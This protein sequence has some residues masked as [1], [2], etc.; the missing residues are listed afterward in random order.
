M[1]FKISFLFVLAAFTGLLFAEEAKEQS[2]EAVA[3]NQELEN[4]LKYV[5]ALVDSG[6]P[7][8]ATLVSEEVK[9][10]WPEAE[11]S[12]FAL[13]VR[14]LLA[15]GKFKEA[16]AKIA[17]L[18]D[19]TGTKY[20]AARL[21]M[22]NS[23]F[24]RGLK[25]ECM[26]IYEE[27][28]SK[29]AKPTKDIA[30]FYN[31]ANWV[32]GQ[33]LMRDNKFDKAVQRYEYALKL[34]KGEDW[35][36]LACETADI[37]LKLIEQSKEKSK[38]DAY[39]KAVTVIINKLLYQFERPVFFGR[40]L[41]MKAHIELLKGDSERAAATIEEYKA[42]LDNLHAQIVE[43][44]PEGKFGLL[45]QSPLPQCLYLKAKILWDEAKK[46]Y[47]SPTRKDERVKELLFGKK[48]GGRRKVETGAFAIAQ[49]IF[50]NYETSS[51]APAAGDMAQEIREFA[52]KNY[53]A[54]IKTRVTDEQREKVR[55]AQFREANEKYVA[56]L[57][58]EAVVAYY[59]VLSRY[60][61]HID[62][63][64][65]VERIATVL[66]D[67]Y[68]EA[69][70]EA[71]KEEKRLDC[72]TIEGYLAERFTGVSNKLIMIGAGDALVRLAAKEE[73]YRD[74]D[75]S[76]AL[77]AAFCGNYTLHPGSP[78]TAASKAG[79][80]QKKK[81]YDKAIYFWNFL[82]NIY[83]NSVFHATA[84]SQLSYCYGEKGDVTNE[85]AYISRYV[86]VEKNKLRKLQAQLKLA[87]MY[88]HSGLELLNSCTNALPENVEALERKGTAQN[89]RAIQNFIKLEKEAGEA[90][91]DPATP[92][93]DKEKFGKARET[94]AYL[95]G[96]CFSRMKRPEKNLQMYRQKAAENFE[97]YIK[98]YPQGEFA[99]YAY[100]H[101]GTIYTALGD[102]V[103]SKNALDDLTKHFPDSD[104]AKNA[105]PRLAANLI[106]IGMKKEGA[107]IYAEMI[108]TDG[109][110]TANQY[111]NAG[112]ALIE[113][114]NWDLANRA[115]EKAIRL[116]PSNSVTVVARGR[117][118]LAKTS[119][120][121]GSLDE[122]RQ[123]LDLFL[124][125]AKMSRLPIAAD[126]YFMLVEV[127]RQQGRNE[128]DAKMRDK[129][130]GAA[131]LA[132]KKV[133]AYWSKKPKCEQDK[134][135][136]TSGDLIIERM[137]AEEK[138][139]LKEEA[140]RSCERAASK[141]QV[142][143]QS[144]GPTE[145]MPISKMDKN[146]IANLEIAYS[147]AISLFAKLGPEQADRVVAFGNEY[148]KYF[149]NGSHLNEVNNY[150]N[151]AKAD[152]PAS[153]AAQQKEDENN[154]DSL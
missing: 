48:E 18:P 141:F 53:K 19:R 135:E 7:D 55:L 148:I 12:L 31:S 29:H 37:Y 8:F 60:P 116:A 97:S 25:K 131:A 79:E 2:V 154:E 74:F 93:S 56:G 122:A 112:D 45:R 14:G 54:K 128:S 10:R 140:K 143:I 114:G 129:Y 86:D 105:K 72:D 153:S 50:L 33:L 75:R 152:I 62:S 127:A 92:A 35:C 145:E 113:S 101:L 80:Y 98:A 22:A 95:I 126:A 30:S 52:E 4:E 100:I 69:K 136:L 23:L 43:N 106:K 34:L 132:L 99:M 42:E 57:Y 83:T 103:K 130:F 85:I 149:P 46:E 134:L 111:L 38:R 84:L 9:K 151:R 5:E 36:N 15:I 40:G 115:Y 17:A 20:W 107:N 119:W 87:R 41:S 63:I 78:T 67:E 77:Y 102:P 21:E 147:R 88:Q 104:A 121:Q 64:A 137:N 142:F 90:L 51:W 61:E 139:G 91:S 32:Y 123:A 133:R 11:A 89:I 117:L 66:L 39:V 81:L 28:F 94:A 65:A 68:M 150:I 71:T 82:D 58:K 109:K 76:D 125:D 13:D 138:K 47:A 144:N 27:F 124:A 70:D 146:D 26:E 118:G 49:G 110:Y 59:D 96:E 24:Q 120:K 1:K 16:E 108:G 73:E 6:F 3:V 44:D